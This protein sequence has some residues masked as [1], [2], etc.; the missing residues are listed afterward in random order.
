MIFIWISFPFA[1]FFTINAVVVVGSVVERRNWIRRSL[2][3]QCDEL[4]QLSTLRELEDVVAEVLSVLVDGPATKRGI[5]RL[6]L[7]RRTLGGGK[8]IQSN[9]EAH[10]Q[11]VAPGGA[12]LEEADGLVELALRLV[13]EATQLVV[14]LVLT[15]TKQFVDT[16]LL[17]N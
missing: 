9:R 2:I 15:L 10:R 1:L 13:E 16:T 6:D 5:L 3:G 17:A 14:E 7:T 11:S 8:T 4:L 12:R